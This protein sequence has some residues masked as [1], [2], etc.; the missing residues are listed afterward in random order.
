MSPPVL[1]AFCEERKQQM[2]LN[3]LKVQV[4]CKQDVEYLLTETAKY[5]ATRNDTVPEEDTKKVHTE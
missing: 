3:E 4:E 5:L 2:T 1:K